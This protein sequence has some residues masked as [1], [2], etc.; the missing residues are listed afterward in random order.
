MSV[1]GTSGA[2]RADRALE[3]LLQSAGQDYIGEAVSQLEH[4]LQSAWHAQQA[5]A[6]NS[7]IL[8]ALFHDIGHWI[9][10]D[11]PQMAGLGVVSHEQLGAE[12]LSAHGFSE[13]VTT[14]VAQHVAA[15]RYLC[16]RHPKYWAGLSQASRG[17]LEW[18]GGIMS[19]E[20]AAAFESNRLFKRILALR[21]WDERAKDPNAEVPELS[22]Y[23]TLIVKHLEGQAE[24]RAE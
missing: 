20:E 7:D 17:T 13:V 3:C 10:P 22:S 15:K 18:Q 12:W 19:K 1:I 6:E 21:T 24:P 4:A 23:C 14:L 8:A 5:G 9:E 11:A 16:F 2:A